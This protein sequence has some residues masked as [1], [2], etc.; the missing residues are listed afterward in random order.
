MIVILVNS[1]VVLQE[2]TELATDN[3]IEK[4]H[5]ETPIHVRAFGLLNGSIGIYSNEVHRIYIK[6][7]LLSNFTIIKRDII[8]EPFKYTY[9]S[10]TSNILALITNDFH[11]IPVEEKAN[12]QPLRNTCLYLK[13]NITGMVGDGNLSRLYEYTVYPELNGFNVK[14]NVM[15]TY[16]RFFKINL[17]KL[18]EGYKLVISP[19]YSKHHIK[20][21]I[22]KGRRNT[23]SYI[24]LTDGSIETKNAQYN[25]F[26][27][28]VYSRLSNAKSVHLLPV[29]N[30]IVLD[31]EKAVV[32]YDIHYSTNIRRFYLYVNGNLIDVIRS[33]NPYAMGIDFH[34]ILN[35]TLKDSVYVSINSTNL[36]YSAT[37]PYTYGTTIELRTS[38]DVSSIDINATIE[39]HPSIVIMPPRGL[40]EYTVNIN[41]SKEI[42]AVFE[43][44]FRY[45]SLYLYP[46]II[47]P[48]EKISF[49]SEGNGTVFNSAEL[50]GKVILFYSYSNN[51]T[52]EITLGTLLSAIALYNIGHTYFLQYYIVPI[53]NTKTHVME[54]MKE[55]YKSLYRVNAYNSGAEQSYVFTTWSVEG[56]Y[57]HYPFN[58]IQMY[59]YI[60]LAGNAALNYPT[61][62][63]ENS[64]ML[65]V[66]T[67]FNITH[68]KRLSLDQYGV[69]NGSIVQ[70]KIC[71]NTSLS[72]HIYIQ[73]E[74]GTVFYLVK[75]PGISIEPNDRIF[76]SENY[77]ISKV[78]DGGRLLVFFTVLSRIPP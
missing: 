40:P 12:Q 67:R 14:K 23:I 4:I 44:P 30:K 10:N 37:I 51:Y 63:E 36:N 20:R 41:R 61:K 70:V 53:L 55:H 3:A 71:L 6:Y 38:N 26:R 39:L 21:Y 45:Y 43:D 2:Y 59:N 32:I 18:N 57:V 77:I 74:P 78:P 52:T 28:T 22:V 33:N 50:G 35:K 75:P 15:Y 7:I 8:L 1:L 48:L 56:I 11:F 27:I 64:S 68:N 42:Y 29:E 76:V 60:P 54:I 5:N 19:L 16:S 49:R 72:G 31:D 46:S 69:F 13:K 25:N 62:I 73:G 47:I 9:I 34:V 65:V 24:N 58:E 66:N 17:D